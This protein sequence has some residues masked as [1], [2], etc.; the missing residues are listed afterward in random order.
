[1]LTSPERKKSVSN[2]SRINHLE[3]ALIAFEKSLREIL[4]TVNNAVKSQKQCIKIVG[5]TFAA[6]KTKGL[7]TDE[8]YNEALEEFQPEA[9]DNSPKSSGS[10]SDVQPE[11][12]GA[13]EDSS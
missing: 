12:A 8:E 1:M 4:D 9:D 7:I 3:G 2:Y 11:G 5:A 10:E 6:L 13:V